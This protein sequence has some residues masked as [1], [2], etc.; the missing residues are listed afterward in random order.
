MRFLQP[1]AHMAFVLVGHGPIADLLSQ[2]PGCC[3]LAPFQA[4]QRLS[5]MLQV[6][7]CAAWPVTEGL[8]CLPAVCRG[9]A[10]KRV[11]GFQ[12]A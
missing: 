1:H 8:F 2:V 11:V 12:C 4:C 3:P 10:S 5:H 6:Q 9:A 7:P